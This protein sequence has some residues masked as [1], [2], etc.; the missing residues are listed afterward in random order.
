MKLKALHVKNQHSAQFQMQQLHHF[1]LPLGLLTCC[2][3]TKPPVCAELT[4][5]TT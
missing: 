4:L 2:R 1:K 3:L 5:Q